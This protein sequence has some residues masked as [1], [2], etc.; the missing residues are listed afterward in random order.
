MFGS[1][2]SIEL[3][4]E[5][6]A[7]QLE[8]E[9]LLSLGRDLEQSI[10]TGFTLSATNSE[11]EVVGGVV[12]NTSYS[13]LLVKILWVEKGQRHSGIG[14]SLM[15]AA[16]AKA[17]ELN[18]HSVWLDTSNPQA[19]QFYSKLGYEVFGNLENAEGQFPSN[20]RRWFMRK[21]LA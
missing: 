3:G 19:H 2:F 17:K 7:E 9:L 4:D 8:V 11:G 1:D 6:S 15:A 10:N 20:H 12:A 13:W 18:C 5:R 21:S 16:E 14:R